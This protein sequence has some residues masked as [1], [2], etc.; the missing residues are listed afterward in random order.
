M[1]ADDRW[2]AAAR[3]VQYERR[4]RYLHRRLADETAPDARLRLAREISLEARNL[5]ELG[6][7]ARA[8]NRE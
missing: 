8:A 2:A 6:P 1:S 5:A 3:R 7:Q 4:L